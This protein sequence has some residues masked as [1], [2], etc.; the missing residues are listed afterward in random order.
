[1]DGG[2]AVAQK[3][4]KVHHLA[5]LAGL[6]HQPSLG[7]DAGFGEGAVDRGHG[8][9]G[10]DG[11]FARGEVAIG[12]DDQA[13]ALG[14][15]AGGLGGQVDERLGQGRAVAAL[16]EGHLEGD[17]AELRRADLPEV[18]ELGIGEDRAAHLDEAGVL[19]GLGED[20]GLVAHVGHQ[21]HHRD[22]ADGVDRRVGHLREALL[23]VVKEEPGLLG[24]DGEGGIVA[25][26]ADRFL[27]VGRHRLEEGG[28]VLAAVAEAGLAGKQVAGDLL[29]GRLAEETVD[30]D[31]VF[32]DPAAVGAAAGHVA[33]NLRIAQQ[34]VRL[35]VEP[36]HF[37]G[38]QTAV[39]L[40]G[41][42]RDV[43]HAGLGG[44]DEGAVLAEGVARGAQAITVEHRPG[45]DAVGEG[46]GRRAIPGLHQRGV[47]LKEAA[48]VVAHVV[49]RAPGLG[50]EHQHRV[51]Q[52]APGLHQQLEHIIQARGVRLPRRHQRDE[53]LDVPAKERTLELPFA[54]VEG[55][56]VAAQGVDFAIVRQKAEG[57]G[58]RPGGE[59][60]GGVALVGQ[61]ERRGE[62]LGLQVLVEGVELMGQQEALIDDAPRR[63]GA[64][65]EPLA[66]GLLQPP[67]RHVEFAL[68]GIR[69]QR[70]LPPRLA[71]EELAD[72]GATLA[73]R[74]ADRLW[75]GGHLTPGKGLEPLLAQDR[76]QPL[77]QPHAPKEHRHAI[78][79]PLG[80]IGHPGAEEAIGQRRQNPG[81]VARLRVP[82]RRPAMGQAP[83]HR[84]PLL[85]NPVTR[86][87]VQVCHHPHAARI[88]LIYRIVKP[89]RRRIRPKSLF[90]LLCYCHL[91]P[92]C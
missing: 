79:P 85:H 64:D 35:Q 9:Q 2:G 82:A 40:N 77:L 42:G 34:P 83:K 36:E 71:D 16:G 84:Q 11:H 33:L 22:L 61:D 41:L 14:C 1:M 65:V 62:V 17:G 23:E 19:G 50:H 74:P 10:G 38:A 51:G 13:V 73:R 37:A 4:G 68:E 70:G 92:F 53:L 5:H 7:A 25:H 49:R 89:L 59:G 8:Q 67:P 26:R 88:V 31:A 76:F 47:I 87:V 15:H 81:P 24:E 44:E 20:V 90:L 48:H 27:A 55:V 43:Q 69:R 72:L 86:P 3:Q 45:A 63:E 52:V 21:A 54:G 30:E 18:L 57:L 75:V 32:L 78:G 28:D 6:H 66:E 29:G 58:Q 46:H 39:A 56:E 12:E 91:L 80:E 60:V